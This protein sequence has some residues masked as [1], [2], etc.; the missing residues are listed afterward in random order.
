MDVFQLRDRLITDYASYISSFIQIRD[1]RI[2][3]QVDH[4]L[5]DGL[6]WPEP[7]IQLN[8]SF[9]PGDLIDDLVNQGEL[10]AGCSRVFL[11]GKDKD[12]TG[13]P[14]QLH[15]HQSDAVRIARGGSNYILTTGTGSGKSLAY[16]IPIVDHVLRNGSGRGVQ[17]IIVYPMNALANSQFG[18]LQ[19]FL[20]QGYTDGK[21]PVTFRRYTGQEKDEERQEILANPP[22]ILL[23]N[24]VMLELI[25]TRPRERNLIRAAQGLRFLVLDELHTYRG[26]QGADVALLVRRV[27][28]ILSAT[29][30]QCVGTSATL[31]GSGTFAEQQA[32]VARVGSILFGS[33]VQPEHVIGETLRRA[34]T[35]RS[36]ADPSFI[37]ELTSRIADENRQPPAE[38]GNFIRDC[39]SIWIESTFGITTEPGST[40]LVRSKPKSISGDYGAA[41]DLSRLTGTPESRC[42]QAIQQ[43]LLAGYFCR[44]PQNGFPAFAFRLHQFISRGDAVYASLRGEGGRYITVHGQRFVPGADPKE[45]LLPVVFC[46]ECGQEYYCVRKRKNEAGARIFEPRELTDRAWEEDNEPG[47]LYLNTSDPWPADPSEVHQRIPEDWLEGH[48]GT[49]RIK[50]TFRDHLPAAVRI[51]PDGSESERGQ[52][53]H[54]I[55][56]PFRF[57]LNCGVAYGSRQLT[58]IGKLTSLGTGGRSTA[59]TILSLSAIRSLRKEESLP[60]KA[61]KL[62]SFTDNRQDASL[63]AGHFNDF[64]EIGLLRSALYRAACVTGDEGI[65]HDALTQ[66]VFDALDLPLALYS[67]DPDVRYAARIETD[68][69]LR[70]L[71]GY[72][73][74]MDQR[75]GWR[76]TSPNLEQ[77]GLLEIRYES[78]DDLCRDQDLWS[79]CH[80]ALTG[81]SPETR[82]KISKV[83]LDFMRRSL[84]IKVDYLDTSFHE[85]L[86]Q[87]SSQRL[88]EPWAIDDNERME[89]AGILF[90]RSSR[91]SDYG[92]FV[93]LS[94]R[95]GFGQYL[96][97]PSTFENG[98]PRLSLNET[99]LICGQLLEVLK[100]AGLITRIREPEDETDVPGYLLQAD[101]MI[102]LA[103]DGT[104]AFHDPIRVPRE[105]AEGSRT[106]PFF[107][108]FYKTIA[109]ET[110]GLEAREHTAQVPY[111]LRIEREDRFRRASLPVLYCSPTMELGVDIAELN[112]VNMRNIPPTPANYAQRSGR[113]GRSGQ[114]ALVF[115][116][117]STGSPHDRYF[118]KRPER[119]VMGSVTTPRLDLA[120]EDLV[121]AHV[122]AIWLAETGQ[123]LGS[124]LRDI[125]D[126]AGEKPSLK[127]LD[128]VRFS[129]E[130]E[131]P[132]RR[133]RGRVEH[134]L[135]T[136][137]EDL[138]KSNWNSERW[139][140][141][142]LNQ[143]TLNFDATCDRWRGLYKAA[144]S[145][146]ELQ[147]RIIGDATRSSFEKEQAK[148]L[149]RE[150]EAQLDLL[151]QSENVIQS[152][153]YSYRYFASEGFL[154]GYNFPR[155][156]LSAYIPG[157][158]TRSDRDEFLSRPRFLAISEFGP[159]AIIYHEGSRYIINKVIL[160]VGEEE[161]ELA[162]RWVKRCE[163][164]GYLHPAK[165]NEGPDLC[166]RCGKLLGPP[167]RQLLRLQNVSTRR[168]DKI[169]SDEEE[170]LRQGYEIIS[171]VRFAEPGTQ[172]S[173]QTARVVDGSSVLAT[174]T[175]GHA[176]TIWRVNLGWVRRKDQGQFGFV[177]DV[178]RGYWSKNPQD[179]ED[180]EQDPN[181]ART[182]RVIPFVEDRR[183]CL[184]FQPAVELDLGTMASLEAAFK[185]AIQ[186]HYQ[187]EDSELA[188]EALPDRDNR[189]LILF[190][191]SAEGGAGVLRNLL[192]DPQALAAVSREALNLMHF[193][194]QSGA[195]LRR[196]PRAREECEAACYDCL[197]SYVN[198]L[199][200]GFL[201]RHAA[202]ELLMKLSTSIV[203]AS[204]AGAPRA[205]HLEQLKRKSDSSL[206]KDWLDH[207]ERYKLRLPSDAQVY[208]EACRTRP[209]FIY[210]E[211]QT[212][213]YIDGP[214]HEF[215]ERHARD[216][217][218]TD[219]MED[220]GYTVIRFTAREDWDAKIAQ[221]PHIFGK[222]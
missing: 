97:R 178:D 197:M 37:A 101:A 43:G 188:V 171:A 107:V 216:Q 130:A 94:P 217:A 100:K 7:L 34:T 164:C 2:K 1:E 220:L 93:Y 191:E 3:E 22:D 169:N 6:L 69:A 150:A 184:L 123:D 79:N 127:L 162:T 176:A 121:R 45:V 26:R 137:K 125:L 50:S 88:K 133:A 32:E 58:D 73:I 166:E 138:A 106:N 90:P 201:D 149:R 55:P 111:E 14:L 104:R 51:G 182:M 183:N 189:R 163:H 114:P 199:D 118:F 185:S 61:R 157:R 29:Q 181:A 74:Y 143:I 154:P 136:M 12:S 108:D 115:S 25:L 36:T 30:L 113:A 38:Y 40:R 200:H 39:L 218:Q 23:T 86:Q 62:L 24:Y 153:F 124:S 174:L 140:D 147:N 160:P 187:L 131:A 177:L 209:D 110:K 16:I 211:F 195:D 170:R 167:L 196:A 210:G 122:Q 172:P 35:E 54:F 132:R 78:L 146:R 221:Y 9:E 213:V 56:A 142:V 168:R 48:R 156:P 152:D 155:L 128:E 11:I 47:Y 158:R 148:R 75:R 151:T 77:C 207:L 103:G 129:I 15:R 190:Y 82:A 161:R 193:D 84:A 63:Q 5:G 99:E 85:R 20:C 60:E 64:I 192:D 8:P 102:W 46:R 208:I 13:K 19:K 96:R 81:A 72:R 180:D 10:Q 98:T 126:L 119:M 71:I 134:V 57:C 18:E 44:N 95:G 141:E 206:E 91:P 105:A 214:H 80:A 222:E 92:G 66:R 202:K 212:V 4:S 186:V 205:G 28:D 120:N 31:A 109:G 215:P 17:A 87:R 65:R 49:L 219:S 68:R 203:Q 173:H 33:P 144:M 117:C 59:T 139:T 175:Y 21:G 52:N 198:Q 165:E 53:C 70:D 179:P 76:I 83:L 27:R 204:P 89:H 145:Q 116:Y 159:R 194:P 112:A 67:R 135:S 42:V 41:Q